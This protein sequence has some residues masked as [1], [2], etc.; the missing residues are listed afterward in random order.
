MS[1]LWIEYQLE[2]G[3]KHGLHICNAKNTVES[4]AKNRRQRWPESA[5]TSFRNLPIYHWKQEQFVSV[6]SIP[7]EIIFDYSIE[8]LILV[9]FLHFIL[10]LLLLLLLLSSSSLLLLLLL[11][12]DVGRACRR[13]FS[14]PRAP[15]SASSGARV[16]QLRPSAR[17]TPS[18]AGGAQRHA[19]EKSS[20]KVVVAAAFFQTGLSRYFPW[21]QY[22]HTY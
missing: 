1:L 22:K 5:T 4:I 12:F 8:T 17:F 20:E 21:N 18:L 15:L 19:H 7:I 2:G 13:T 3:K 11:L 9:L 16:G 6:D 10:F 14:V